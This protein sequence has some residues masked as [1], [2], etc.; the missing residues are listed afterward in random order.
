M[1]EKKLYSFA[2]LKNLPRGKSFIILK[3]YEKGIIPKIQEMVRKVF[4]G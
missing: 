3:S 4:G 2:I 1:E